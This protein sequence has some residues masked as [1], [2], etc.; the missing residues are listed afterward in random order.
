MTMDQL[1]H[2]DDE[3]LA[4]FASGDGEDV[5]RAHVDACDRC[6]SIVDDLTSL[7][8]SLAELPDLVPGRPLRLLPPVEAAAPSR[9]GFS[10]LV[11]RLFAPAIAAGV[12]LLL[13][14]SVG[15]AATPGT[16]DVFSGAAGGAPLDEG[17][18]PAAASPGA[19]YELDGNA[20]DSL[21][22]GPTEG[23]VAAEGTGRLG[24]GEEDQAR[25]L[26]LEASP[27]TPW[28]AITI[29]GAVLLIIALVLRWTVVPRSPDPPAYPGA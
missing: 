9:G 10:T 18:A 5:L 20:R 22:A 13:V 21:S 11:R 26:R 6:A 7:R 19:A 4:A 24:A 28:L 17:A 16:M 25:T 3:R 1:T 29:T 15:L 27:V 2:P 12:A 8:A 14:G 23:A